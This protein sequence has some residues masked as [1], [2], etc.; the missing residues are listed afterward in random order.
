MKGVAPPPALSVSEEVQAPASV[1]LESAADIFRGALWAHL[2]MLEKA[3]A[4]EACAFAETSARLASI[5]AVA[6]PQPHASARRPSKDGSAGSP[7]RRCASFEQPDESPRAAMFPEI[8]PPDP[9]TMLSSA[10]QHRSAS[11]SRKTSAAFSSTDSTGPVE[12]ALSIRSPLRSV[13]TGGSLVTPS[14]SYSRARTMESAARKRQRG[15]TNSEFFSSKS[16]D[17][18]AQWSQML[19]AARDVPLGSA[20]SHLSLWKRARLDSRFRFLLLDSVMGFLIFANSIVI[21]VSADVAPESFVWTCL[22]IVFCVVFGLEIC[23]KIALTGF[24]DYWIGE[25]RRWNVFEVVLVLLGV[26]DICITVYSAGGDGGA[27]LAILRV[28]RLARIARIL[29]VFRLQMFCDLIVMIKGTVGGI[30][31]LT[32]A[33]GLI[34]FPMYAF[35]LVFR[36]TLGP[37][38]SHGNGAENFA[39]VG[40]SFFTVYRC[41]VAGECTDAQGRPIFALVTRHYGW[42]HGL[43]YCA[44]LIFMSFGLFNV[45][46]A[47]FVE[48]VLA[49]AKTN[50][51]IMKRQR[52]RDQSFFAGKMMDLLSVLLRT[53]RAHDTQDGEDSILQMSGA[54]MIEELGDFGITRELFEEAHKAPGVVELLKDLDIAD[55]DDCSDLFM[56]LDSDGDGVINVEELFEGIGRLRGDARRSDIISINLKMQRLH[57]DIKILFEVLLPEDPSLDPMGRTGSMELAAPSF[58]ERAQSSGNWAHR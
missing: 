42:V 49:G 46:V 41:F 36:E 44:V 30:K 12:G 53:R 3:V 7:R 38:A 16:S 57:N 13:S 23:V 45:I 1:D 22:D 50:D 25:D 18:P 56:T 11:P 15:P 37:L 31:T 4:L 32:L 14:R 51:Q 2:A 58:R 47:I 8:A 39:T 43:I 24:R 55:G 5:A 34:S 9:A 35:A 52:L 20:T 27:N 48:N 33:A 17:M 19:D 6:P 28:V 26:L 29:R 40:D 21:G 54:K 10:S